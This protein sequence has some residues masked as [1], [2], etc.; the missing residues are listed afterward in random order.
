[1]AKGVKVV[2]TPVVPVETRA[3]GTDQAGT[4][5]PD[6]GGFIPRPRPQTDD[7]RVGQKSANK[8][9]PGVG[10]GGPGIPL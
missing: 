10:A 5:D 3:S 7:Q 2:G 9:L 8:R 6:T 4:Y 1:M